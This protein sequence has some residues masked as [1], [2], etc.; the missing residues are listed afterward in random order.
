MRI[1]RSEVVSR[2]Q[3]QNKGQRIQRRVG[4]VARRALARERAEIAP[5]RRDPPDQ[6]KDTADEVDENEQAGEHDARSENV[7]KDP[8]EYENEANQAGQHGTLPHPPLRL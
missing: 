5:A 4:A 7:A 6:R 1:A 8:E 3:E 2:D